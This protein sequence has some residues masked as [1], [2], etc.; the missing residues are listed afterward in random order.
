MIDSMMGNWYLKRRND[1]TQMKF[2]TSLLAIYIVV[3]TPALTQ[4]KHLDVD[5]D[6]KIRGSIDM[7]HP[8]DTSSLFIGRNA[9]VNTTFFASRRNTFFGSRAGLSN[10]SGSSDS[11]FGYQA[12]ENNK[13]GFANSFFGA[14]AGFLN[15]VGLGN[16]F[17][18][19]GAGTNNKAGSYNSYFGWG[20]GVN[21]GDTLD[22]AIAIGYNAIVKCS[23]CAV[24]GGTG[25]DSVYVGIN[26]TTPTEQLDVN[27]NA[28]IRLVGTGPFKFPLSLANE[29][30]L[31]TDA[32]DE[33]LKENIST[34]EN[35]MEITQG[36]RGIRYNWK[37]D[38]HKEQRIGLIAQEV[39]KV[40]PEVVYTNKVDGYMGVR[41][42][43]IVAL[44][45]EGIKEQQAQIESLKADNSAIL[46]RLNRLEAVSKVAPHS[47]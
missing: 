1:N 29:G 44:L 39:A 3:I 2:L 32:S 24:I 6:V 25:A 12:G 9:G 10:T 4:P 47:N 17:F 28:R 15:D 11:F 23:N 31:T 26:T 27:G 40:L 34:I 43:E 38:Q 20:A 35:A 41:Y 7:N 22:K 36:L 21:F 45:I 8:D 5:G 13:G 19:S 30:V 18:G 37:E 16:S 46:K 33:R 42:K 14:G